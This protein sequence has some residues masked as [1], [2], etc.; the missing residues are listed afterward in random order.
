MP[1][2]TDGR[3]VG[4]KWVFRIKENVDG[5]VNKYKAR[6]VAKGFNQV[7]G[8]DFHEAFSP[9][10]KPIMIM[11][12]CTIALTNEWNLFHLDVNIIF[13][14]GNLD[15]TVYMVQSPRFEVSNESLV[16]RH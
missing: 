1:L 4:C 6:L 2:P 15:G 9:I 3:V 16:C 14:N 7:H 13:L 12:I 5:T 8:F 10:V 11:I